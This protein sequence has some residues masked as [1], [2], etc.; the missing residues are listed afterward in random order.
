MTGNTSG[1]FDKSSS[2]D[3]SWADHT[4]LSKFDSDGELLWTEQYGISKSVF[5]NGV[6][7]DSNDAVYITGYTYGR[8][9]DK[10]NMFGSSDA[11]ISKY[12]NNGSKIWTRQFGSSE[13]EETYGI[14]LDN[15]NILITGYTIGN[16]GLVGNYGG[17]DVFIIK[18]NRNGDKIFAA[19][20]ELQVIILVKV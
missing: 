5:S 19:R 6:V 18:Y 11:Y 15:L 1:Q 17:R 16:V 3:S 7:V 2:Y 13:Y 14:A 4:F 9:G 10:N 8:V 12:N 20:L